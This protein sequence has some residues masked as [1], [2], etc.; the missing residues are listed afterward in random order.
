M[1]YRFYRNDQLHQCHNLISVFLPPE[2]DLFKLEPIAGAA[3]VN[4]PTLSALLAAR[5]L[6]A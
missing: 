5:E 3:A 2:L 6:D 4:T 1:V